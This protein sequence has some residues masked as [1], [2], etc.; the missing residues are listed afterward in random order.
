MT[1]KTQP[2]QARKYSKWWW[3]L[4]AAVIIPISLV[5]HERDKDAKEE[6]LAKEAVEAAKSPELRAKE[7]AE[8]D[9]VNAKKALIVVQTVALK[10]S[11]KDPQAFVLN[12]LK[13]TPSGHGCIDYRAKNSFGA[14]FPGSAVVLPT[15]KL[16][17]QERD[18][19]AFVSVWNNFCTKADGEDLTK[20]A[21]KQM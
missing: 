11:M 6:R 8:K 10:N 7:K 21:I 5:N 4:G 18:N 1:D 13:A 15:G 14:V 19:N 20:F 12:S 2:K 17:V 3:A 16:L 9:K